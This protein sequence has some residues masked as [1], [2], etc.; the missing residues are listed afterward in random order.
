VTVD[1][2]PVAQRAAVDPAVKRYVCEYKLNRYEDKRLR[3]EMVSRG[4]RFL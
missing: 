2:P 1:Q 3:V 4:A